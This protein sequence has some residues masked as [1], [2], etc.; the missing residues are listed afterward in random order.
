M[1]VIQR[2]DGLNREHWELEKALVELSLVRGSRSLVV[3]PNG[4]NHQRVTMGL[5]SHP[6]VEDNAARSQGC[7]LVASRT[8]AD[9]ARCC[10][11]PS[12]AGGGSRLG[13]LRVRGCADLCAPRWYWRRSGVAEPKPGWLRQGEELGERY[14]S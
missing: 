4:F 6:T 7:S 9:G 2:L 14:D 11:G 12:V 8:S 1:T 3:S 10:F 5:V 13:A